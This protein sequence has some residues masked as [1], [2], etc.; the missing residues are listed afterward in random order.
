MAK[1]LLFE[2]L[3][4]QNQTTAFDELSLYL[5]FFHRCT[6]GPSSIWRQFL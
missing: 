3:A 5:L 1:Y 6:S 2:C 4:D